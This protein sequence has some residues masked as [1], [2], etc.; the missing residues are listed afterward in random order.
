MPPKQYISCFTSVL[1]ETVGEGFNDWGGRGYDD[2]V[3]AEV[4]KRAPSGDETT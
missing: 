2:F 4:I 1:A 3:P